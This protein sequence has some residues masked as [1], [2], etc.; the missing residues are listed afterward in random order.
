MKY[1]SLIIDF[2]V[3]FVAIFGI[4]G[5]VVISFV[6][7]AARYGFNYSFTWASELTIYLFLWSMFFTAAFLFKTNSHI[8]ITLLIGTLPKK[9]AKWVFILTQSISMIFLG[10]VAYFGYEY[11]LLVNEIEEMSID[12]DIPM[13]IPYLVIP[14]AFGLGVYYLIVNIFITIMT[15]AED[16]S[17]K[18]DEADMLQDADTVVKEVHKKTG[19]ML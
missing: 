15:P 4:S 8:S 7:V 2:V 11:L 17:F 3:K 13:W 19:G 14:L 12:L 18:H 1:I 5:G 10:V 16:L 6:N 9:Y